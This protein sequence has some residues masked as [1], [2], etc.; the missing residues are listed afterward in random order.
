MRDTHVYAGAAIVG[1]IAG[2]RSMAAP[3]LVSRLGAPGIL[4]VS[5]GT[6]TA[7]LAIG[8]AIAD[9]LP[10]MPSRTMPPSLITRAVSG[11]LSG[12]SLT[13]SRRRSP[14]WGAVIGAAAAVGATYAAYEFRQ[15][16]GKRLNVPDFVVA[17]AED[18]VVAAAAACLLSR[19]RA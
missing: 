9:K 18:A 3:A 6:V 16:A 15:R 14:F 5:T 13:S 12:A 1:V 17:L 11:G 10:F 4:P 2:M 7:A 19:F 8:E